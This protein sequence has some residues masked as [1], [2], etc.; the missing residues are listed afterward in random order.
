MAPSVLLFKA[1]IVCKGH[2]IGHVKCLQNCQ[3]GWTEVVV[4]HNVAVNLITAVDEETEKADSKSRGVSSRN[5]VES[6][7]FQQRGKRGCRHSTGP[8]LEAIWR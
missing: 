5:D 3:T 6:G 2:G 1:R 8:L 4:L 7:K